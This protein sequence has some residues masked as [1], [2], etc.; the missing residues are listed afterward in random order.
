MNK[1]QV[2]VLIIAVV[3]FIILYIG[4]SFLL[5]YS[6]SVR[7]KGGDRKVKKSNKTSAVKMERDKDPAI[8]ALRANK[9]RIHED[10]EAF[11]R[12]HHEEEIEVVSGDGLKLKGYILRSSGHKWVIVI[13]G[14][15]MDHTS[16]C[17]MAKRYYEE[18]YN[19]LS[20][21][22]RSCG[23][24]QGEYCGMGWLEK[25]DIKAWINYIVDRDREAE[26]VI[27]GV[28]MGGATVLM[29][30]GDQLAKQVKVLIEDCGYTSVWDIFASEIKL[31]FNLATFPIMNIASWQ[32]KRKAGYSFEEASSL[33]QVEKSILPM[34][35]IHAK[36][37]RFVPFW[38]LDAVYERKQK[39]PKEKVISERGGHVES[40]YAL[41]DEYWNKVFNFI[42]NN[43]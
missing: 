34:M 19:T 17:D 15:R 32:S 31:R 40:M 37:D 33:A 7:G 13:H 21:D 2:I 18:G 25:E 42:K 4:A 8:I 9:K 36:E 27:H 35:F 29:L 11:Y 39:G 6:I 20:P 16:V 12:T 38:M 41:G 3:L 24:S 43:C 26:I 5:R 1:I 14:Y 30:S 28:S 10:S 23:N 22:L